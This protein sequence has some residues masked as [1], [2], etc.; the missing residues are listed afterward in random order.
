MK[1]LQYRRREERADCRR[2]WRS[3]STGGKKRGQTV[4]GW[5]DLSVQEERREGGLREAGEILQ[6]TCMRAESVDCRILGRNC[7]V[8]YKERKDNAEGLGYPQV[9]REKR[10]GRGEEK[11]TG[12]IEILKYRR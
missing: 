9:H 7:T 5:V 3:F 8:Q 10:G 11:E 4:G 2:L 12:E 6:Y 1:I